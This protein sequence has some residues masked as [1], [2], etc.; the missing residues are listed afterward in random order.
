M[1][2]EILAKVSDAET[3]ALLSSYR[4][5]ILL[6]SPKQIEVIPSFLYEQNIPSI[7]ISLVMANSLAV[8]SA[9]RREN[10][11]FTL[12][13]KRTLMNTSQSLWLNRLHILFEPSLNQEPIKLLKLLSKQT[14][15][16][17]VWPGDYDDKALTYSLPGKPDYKYYPLSELKDVQV[18]YACDRSL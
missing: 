1:L 12:L 4:L 5:V 9:K 6:L 11:L 8:L 17:V 13:K 10:E 3:A 2:D 7:N 14:F 16:V 18:V 15:M